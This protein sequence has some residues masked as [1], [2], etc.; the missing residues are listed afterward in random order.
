MPPSSPVS[1]ASSTTSNGSPA[2]PCYENTS[3]NVRGQPTAKMPPKA[4]LTFD[5][6]RLGVAFTSSAMSSTPS[7][8]RS[9]P[10]QAALAGDRLAV[11]AGG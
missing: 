4:Y 9:P 2:W 11:P 1:G 10:V 5:S 8:S 7:Q 6:S 3:L